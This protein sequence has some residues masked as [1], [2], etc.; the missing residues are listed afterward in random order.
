MRALNGRWVK[1]ELTPDG[2]KYRDKQSGEERD[3][4]TIKFLALYANEEE[5]RAAYY[6]DSGR[7]VPDEDGTEAIPGFDAPK[8]QE[9]QSPKAITRETAMQFLTA[10]VKDGGSD[11]GKL[12][13]KLQM[14]PMITEHFPIGSD[15]LQAAIGTILAA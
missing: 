3:S 2:R 15:E 9:A 11:V 14:M 5:C 13:S 7:E 4:T 6:A 8:P 10:L 12:T 1:V